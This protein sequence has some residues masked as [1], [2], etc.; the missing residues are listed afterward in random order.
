MRAFS[1]AIETL[2]IDFSRDALRDLLSP[3]AID[4]HVI[5]GLAIMSI[6]RAQRPGSW[7]RCRSAL[8][9][10]RHQWPRP[11]LRQADIG[12]IPGRTGA[13]D[14]AATREYPDR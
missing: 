12:A 3:R 1:G 4:Q 7:R 13:I 10:D 9:F 2:T 6:N 5:L 11:G 14:H 8:A